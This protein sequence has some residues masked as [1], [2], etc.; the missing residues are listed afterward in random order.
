[1]RAITCVDHWNIQM[2]A[3]KSAAPEAACLITRQ[4]GF[5]AFS[6]CTVSSSDS[7]FLRLEASA[8]RFMVSAPSREAAVP[9]LMRVRVELSKKSQRYGFAS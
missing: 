7:P 9:K 2:R 6:V 1:M 3:T 8:C 4:S 5:M